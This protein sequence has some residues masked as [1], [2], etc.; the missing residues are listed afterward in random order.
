[1]ARLD[2][3]KI[4]KLR[5]GERIGNLATGFCAVVLIYFIV[6][7]TVARVYGDN[8]LELA[9]LISAPVLMAAGIA[10]S[11]Y[12]ALRYGNR[13]NAEI[14]S[15][16]RDTMIENAALMHP[17]RNSLSFYISIDDTKTYLQ[18]NGY[19]E[20]ITFDFSALGKLSVLRKAEILTETENRLC[21]T[22]CRLYDRGAEYVSVGYSEREGTRKKSGKTVYIIENGKPDIKSYKIYL[23]NNR[24]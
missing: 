21:A 20:K 12:C 23:K 8:T 7:F 2:A 9:T 22:F 4:K 16:I 1:M 14:R 5:R 17:E 15:Y 6:C 13:L 3:E 24:D 19:K 10:A 18:V 11:A